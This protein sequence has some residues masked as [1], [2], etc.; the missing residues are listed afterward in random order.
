M[1]EEEKK[2]HL[3]N[4]DLATRQIQI[5]EWAYNDKMETLFAF[6]LVFISL[7]L[8]SVLFYFK[9]EGMLSGYF[10]WYAFLVLVLIVGLIII[11]R[12]IY[13]ARVRDPKY[14]SRREF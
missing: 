10:V 2:K 4:I 13:T 8:L 14:W 1:D 5:N 9:G 7:I 3:Y 12:A 6:Q 11:Y